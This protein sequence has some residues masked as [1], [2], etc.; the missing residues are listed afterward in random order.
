MLAKQNIITLEE[1]KLIT[2]GL[3]KIKEEIENG[4]FKFLKIIEDIHMNIEARL[5]EIIGNTAGKL[6]TARSRNGQVAL[7]CKLYVRNA[8][9]N[10]VRLLKELKM[11]IL[12]K[13]EQYYD[14]PM[15][16]CT[17]L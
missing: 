17:H 12:N 16:G 4:N 9:D 14:I 10:L 2:F 3:E 5:K 6:H 8:I 1:S 11:E 7:D 13:A 15:A